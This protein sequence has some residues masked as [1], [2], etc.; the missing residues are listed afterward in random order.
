[1]SEKDRIEA[2]RQ[3]CARYHSQMTA[4]RNSYSFVAMYDALRAYDAAQSAGGADI[5]VGCLYSLESPP[6]PAC[7]F[8]LCER[9]SCPRYNE[10]DRPLP[11]SQRAPE[12]GGDF[13]SE[14]DYRIAQEV[15]TQEK[16]RAAC[17]TTLRNLLGNIEA[18]VTP[19][20]ACLRECHMALT[21]LH[22]SPTPG[23]ERAEIV[24]W[25]RT[26]YVDGKINITGPNAAA[27]ELMIGS[28]QSAAATFADA[29]ERGE[30]LK[31]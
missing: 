27:L 1:M 14:E 24:A 16:G 18:G 8:G 5:G 31:V 10:Q 11:P 23:S 12:S 7:S 26:N 3:A 6:L 22:L 19:S 25:L 9:P 15:I 20:A 17:V 28:M 4:S 29:I 30:H 2:V 21:V 13:P